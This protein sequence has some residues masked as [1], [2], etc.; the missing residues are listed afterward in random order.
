MV[1]DIA[2]PSNILALN[3]AIKVAQ[4]CEAGKGFR[5]GA[6][7]VRSL[8]EQSRQ[9]AGQ[10]KTIWG[11]IQ[12]VTSQTVMATEQGTEDVQAGSAQVKH[13]AEHFS[14][15]LISLINQRRRR[16]KLLRGSNIKR[17]GWI[18]LQFA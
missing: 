7:E 12:R 8:A 13:T 16:N 11:D 6:D 2:E 18:R 9:A 1:T 14:S 5:V 15:W 17:L 3:A 10:V 4:A